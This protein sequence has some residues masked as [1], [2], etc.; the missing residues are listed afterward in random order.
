M[1]VAWLVL[2]AL[3][4]LFELHHLAFY[5]LFGA[6]GSL[7]AAAV[8]VFAPSVVV[9]QATTAIAVALTGVVAV[10]PV[11]SKAFA[12]HRGG[13]VTVRG[14]MGAWPGRR[15]SRSTTSAAPTWSATCGWPGSAGW[16]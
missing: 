11:V 16:R 7:A 13:H 14:C 6:I 4:L 2:G 8:A 12:S 5:A 9:A 3:L 15:R 10:R 1:V